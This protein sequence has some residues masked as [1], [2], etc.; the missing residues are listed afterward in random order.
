VEVGRFE[1][2]DFKMKEQDLAAFFGLELAMMVVDQCLTGPSQ[3]E[4][5]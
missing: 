4:Q 3:Q 1:I 2:R 5:K